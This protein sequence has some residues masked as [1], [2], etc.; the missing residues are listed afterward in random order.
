[1]S[2]VAGNTEV[3]TV[4]LTINGQEV[5]GRAG[6][7]IL[8]VAQAAGIDIPTLCHDPRLEP[9]GACRM[10]LVEVEG[11]RGP[12]ASCGTTVRDGMKVQTNTDKIIKM[13]KFVLELLLTNHPLDCPVCEAAGDCKLQDYAY[14]YLVD[15]VPWGWR[16]PEAVDP[17][18]H[19]NI[20]HYGSRC[21]L[22]GRCVRICREVMGIGCWGYL[23]RGYDSEVDTPY[24][25]PL[26]DVECVSCGQCVSTCPVGA[27]VGQRSPQGAR[28]WQTTKTVSTCSY[29]ADGCRLVLHGYQDKV[30]RVASE[31]DKGLNKGSL[32]V[33]GR[34][35]MGYAD[36][37]DRVTSPLVRD[38]KGELQKASWDEALKLVSAKLAAAAK[39]NNGQAVAA[40]CGTHATNEAGYLLQKLMRTV[41]GS[42]N[43][44]TID[45]AESTAF[46]EALT[47]SLGSAAS[48]SSRQSLGEASVI[49]VVGANLTE[50]HPVLALEVVKALREGKRVIVIDPRKTDI[51][52]KATMHL[53]V[54][55]GTDLAAL[56][57]M[58]RY[59]LDLGLADSEFVKSRTEGF[60]TLEASLKGMELGVE[61]ASCGVDVEL[62]R[63]A[64]VAFGE[65]AAATIIVGTGVAH[66]PKATATV[67][68]LV[69]LALI[70]GNVGRPGTGVIPLKSGANSQGLYDMGVRPDRLPGEVA[71]T[72]SEALTKLE[73]AWGVSLNAVSRGAST[74]ELLTG[75]KSA[76][77]SV[78]YVMGADPALGVA[79]EKAAREALKKAEFVILQDSFLS[80]TAEYADVVLPA[81]VSAED[82]GTFTNGERF[83]Q[84]VR[85]AVPPMGE[86]MPDWQIVQSLGNALGADWA[87]QSPA[88]V[89]REIAEI[90]PSYSGVDYE[91]LESDVLQT[92]CAGADSACDVI[93]YADEFPRGKAV[94]LPLD[95][96]V[97]G[98]VIDKEFP[99]ALIT[100]SVR[101]H[102]GTGVRSRRSSGL[103]KIMSEAVLEVNAGDAQQAKLAEGDKVK[104]VSQR[105][106][107]V[108]VA[109]KI[110]GQVPAGVVFLPGFSA[111][112]PVTRLQG[113][114]GSTMPAVRIEKV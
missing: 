64:A 61:A 105:G 11:A 15:M 86:S 85:P 104:V 110:S 82:Q 90:V 80:D 102:H 51:A 24:R 7:T 106:G 41:V 3:R 78:L 10:C 70:T 8:E 37:P 88:D 23:N 14:E 84:R 68:A 113:H 9:Y 50:S 89:M 38:A 18:Q 91:R 93:L 22:C 21:I 87:Y 71:L 27:I 49:L 31:T 55:P 98:V 13:R 32:C 59:V 95:G 45:H 66:G 44:D 57:G 72:S 65:A 92:Q 96:T 16:P 53:A 58:L 74:S 60:T 73:K 34:F 63:A 81:A 100:G 103:T 35:G 114:E 28:A 43:V 30:V 36:S 42:N 6:Q 94:L 54:K 4:E 19:P 111:A 101:E 17:G 112:A 109:V 56:R 99:L 76:V 79:D 67:S 108:D 107:S 47:A 69:D 29:C 39:G 33:K 40:V 46:E 25:L 2:A 48:T 20:A 1:M 75:V 77:L 12:M 5:Q 52:D 83:V 62:L 26:K 97:A